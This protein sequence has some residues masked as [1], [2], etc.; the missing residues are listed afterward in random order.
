MATIPRTPSGVLVQQIF[1][2]TLKLLSESER[3]QFN[4]KIAQNDVPVLELLCFNQVNG[5]IPKLQQHG[6]QIV[7][8]I[9]TIL[10]KLDPKSE[11]VTSNECLELVSIL[12]KKHE[13][14][15]K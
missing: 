3:A 5:E 14:F 6:Q 7:T 1:K 12:E 2:N 15:A 9:K 11:I 4:Q 10:A 13:N 8:Q